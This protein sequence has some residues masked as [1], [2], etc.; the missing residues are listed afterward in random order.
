MSQIFNSSPPCFFRRF[1]FQKTKQAADDQIHN[2]HALWRRTFSNTFGG[3][4]DGEATWVARWLTFSDPETT[5]HQKTIP[6]TKQ[7]KKTYL[8]SLVSFIK[9]V[10]RPSC[11]RDAFLH[12]M[13]YILR[14]KNSHGLKFVPRASYG[15]SYAQLFHELYLV[16]TRKHV[17]R[18]AL[19]NQDAQ[20]GTKLC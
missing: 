19:Q 13:A 14:F 8:V 18:A 10:K 4:N 3:W 17:F 12:A 16:I 1:A 5:V 20:G 15:N 7:E 11:W 6:K 9:K 2:G